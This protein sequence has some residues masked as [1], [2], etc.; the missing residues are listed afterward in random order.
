M[1]ESANA[2]PLADVLRVAASAWARFRA[3]TSLDRALELAQS[4]ALTPA[5]PRLAAAAKDAAYTATRHLALIEAAITRLAGRTPDAAASALA[6]VALGQLLA[7]RR[8]EYVVVDQAVRAA[9]ADVATR[10]ASGFINAL[11]RRWLRERDTLLPELERDD[12]VR[13]NAPR[14]WIDRVRAAHPQ[15]A[16]GIFEVQRAAP[17]L[18]LRVNR[19]RTTVAAYLELLTRA[20]IAASQ[21]GA[22]AV[23][24]HAP[25]PVDAIPG[26]GDGAVSVQD[27]GAQLAAEWLGVR[28]GMRV[29]DACAAPGGKSAQLAETADIELDAVDIDPRR[30]PRIES[31]LART[32]AR[33]HA[34]IR[35]I[36]GDAGKP[37]SFAPT[38]GYD[39]ILL[40]APC[41]ASGIVRR[42][43]DIA[44]LRRPADV[45]QLATQQ[46]RLADALWPVLAP[47]GR[48][49]YVVCSVFPEEGE[50]Q[51]E[52]LAARWADARAVP[53]ASTT[54]ASVQLLPGETAAAQ[55][56]RGGLPTVH[57]GFFFALFEKS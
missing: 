31:N 43:P 12:V 9:K 26:F 48:L 34:R 53:L 14:W 40:D 23:R 52:R 5:H 38:A 51:A 7:S 15:Y 16:D 46:A 2:P 20:G 41:T 8:A 54:Q 45:A 28:A 56:Y 36:V 10:A 42:H 35:V 30:A 25:R 17:P 57:D 47:A 24:L 37:Q 22:Y 50:H 44:W 6:A 32:S 19:R 1:N 27:A 11:L 4:A 49:L 13:L 3:G 55:P 29:L 33:E 21:V 39:R 18:V